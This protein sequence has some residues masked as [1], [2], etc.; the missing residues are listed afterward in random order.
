MK[1]ELEHIKPETATSEE[2]WTA[3]ISDKDSYMILKLTE[4]GYTAFMYLQS[5][6]KEK[7]VVISEYHAKMIADKESYFEVVEAHDDLESQLKEAIESIEALLIIIDPR[8]RVIDGQV[9]GKGR[10]IK[11]NR[12]IKN[13][14]DLIKQKH[15]S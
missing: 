2:K 10:S 11:W 12:D 4:V 8:L 9:I 15:D 5:Q 7:D 6:L 3:Y 13:A 14:Q 1:I